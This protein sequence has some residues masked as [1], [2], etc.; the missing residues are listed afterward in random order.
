VG[1]VVRERERERESE[2]E[3]EREEAY[4]RTF[5]GDQGQADLEFRA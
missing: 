5:L 2:R 3:R 1:V 4:T